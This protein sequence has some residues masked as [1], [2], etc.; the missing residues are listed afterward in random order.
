MIFALSTTD[1][2]NGY[3]LRFDISFCLLLMYLLIQVIQTVIIFVFGNRLVNIPYILQQMVSNVYTKSEKGLFILFTFQV[4]LGLPKVIESF[5]WQVLIVLVG[6]YW[7]TN[8]KRSISQLYA[9]CVLTG[10]SFIIDSLKLATERSIVNETNS[11]YIGHVTNIVFIIFKI[12]TLAIIVLSRMYEKFTQIIIKKHLYD[13]DED[14]EGKEDNDNNDDND[15]NDD[16][17]DI[18]SHPPPKRYNQERRTLKKPNFDSDDSSDSDSDDQNNK[19]ESP[20]TN[21]KGGFMIT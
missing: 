8:S 10:M 1:T 6:I 7:L 2:V 18:E 16:N 4:F 15:D 11:E 20:I 19:N 14:N 12:T 3:D 17:K 9:Y 5:D 21:T 13:D